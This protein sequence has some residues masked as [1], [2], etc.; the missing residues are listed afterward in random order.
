MAQSRYKARYEVRAGT[1]IGSW[2]DLPLE[3]IIGYL[4][5]FAPDPFWGAE[6]NVVIDLETGEVVARVPVPEDGNCW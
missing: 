2:P 1:Y 3:Q 5:K 6:E 4:A